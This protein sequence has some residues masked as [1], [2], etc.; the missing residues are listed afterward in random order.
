MVKCPKWG[1]KEQDLRHTDSEKEHRTDGPGKM[2]AEIR[3]MLHI[4][5]GVPESGS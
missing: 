5:Q 4:S 2:E 1:K 3:V